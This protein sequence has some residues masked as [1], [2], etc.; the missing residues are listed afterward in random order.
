MTSPHKFAWNE[1][2]ALVGPATMPVNISTGAAAGA[3]PFVTGATTTFVREFLVGGTSDGNIHCTFLGQGTAST[4]QTIPVKAGLRYPWA[5]I[6]VY[7][8]GTTV[9]NLWGFY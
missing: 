5:L 8:S 7:S 2:F 1:A 6:K 9:D 3:I 4:G